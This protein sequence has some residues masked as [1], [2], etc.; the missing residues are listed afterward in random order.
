QED[1]TDLI[2]SEAVTRA[3]SE[4]A[5][6]PEVREKL[7]ALQR[8]MGNGVNAVFEGRDM[9]TIVFPDAH[10]KIYLTGRAE[11][12]AKRRF[13]EMLIRFPEEAKKTSLEE[14]TK[15]INRRDERDSTREIA[16]LKQADDAYVVDTS[17]LTIDEVVFKILEL[18]DM[19][20][21]QSS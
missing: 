4:V 21:Q 2:R 13:E 19:Q 5:A 11:V 16:P 12:R 18:K 9:G 3:V 8:E 7:V 10:L 14:M 17:D 1:V 15:D 6:I 20:K